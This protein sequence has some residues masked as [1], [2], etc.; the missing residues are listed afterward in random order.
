MPSNVQ[1]SMH[2]L[3]V[4]V[5][6]SI[7]VCTICVSERLLHLREFDDAPED[8][9]LQAL[10]ANVPKYLTSIP[11]F[12]VLIDLNRIKVAKI[13]LMSHSAWVHERDLGSN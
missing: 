13:Q 9:L 1:T 8:E 3:A 5:S 11:G 10:F 6:S 4:L 2:S 12:P 7:I